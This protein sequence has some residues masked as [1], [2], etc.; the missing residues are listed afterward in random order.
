VV[1]DGP[2]LF[3]SPPPI[4]MNHAVTLKPSVPYPSN[5]IVQHEA[6]TRARSDGSIYPT[7]CRTFDPGQGE[8]FVWPRTGHRK[9]IWFVYQPEVVSMLNNV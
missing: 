3:S 5:P 1:Y 2:E 6:D 7:I 9:S 8:T 4:K